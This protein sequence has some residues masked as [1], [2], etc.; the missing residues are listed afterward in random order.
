MTTPDIYDQ[1][2]NIRRPATQADVDRLVRIAGCYRWVRT[3]IDGHA[4]DGDEFSKKLSLLM[5]EFTYSEHPDAMADPLME[6]FN[7]VSTLI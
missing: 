5:D 4:S 3:K 2:S 7:R 6:L 1:C